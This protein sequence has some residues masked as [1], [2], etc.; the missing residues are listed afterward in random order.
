MGEL[1]HHEGVCNSV[2]CEQSLVES[3]NLKLS[4]RVQRYDQ[5]IMTSFVG[6]SRAQPTAGEK[7]SA[8]AFR[9][10]DIKD[11]EKREGPR[12]EE[13]TSTAT[14]LSIQANIKGRG[15]CVRMVL[16]HGQDSLPEKR[17]PRFAA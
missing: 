1:V 16:G 10:S 7:V 13:P 5:L 3:F 2:W 4:Y 14:R 9:C 6:G 17:K 11:S 8:S 15:A 12:T